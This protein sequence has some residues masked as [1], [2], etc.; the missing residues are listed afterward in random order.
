MPL[1]VFRCNCFC[2]SYRF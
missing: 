1:L 2:N